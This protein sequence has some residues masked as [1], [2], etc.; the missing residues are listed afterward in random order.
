M[1]N[2]KIIELFTLAL[3]PKVV[4]NIFHIMYAQ[5]D[6]PS[7][8]KLESKNTLETMQFSNWEYKNKRGAKDYRISFTME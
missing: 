7:P 6:V 4:C 1:K 5:Y 2:S 3:Y 8:F